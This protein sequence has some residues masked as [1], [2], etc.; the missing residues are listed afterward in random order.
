MTPMFNKTDP[1]NGIVES[2]TGLWTNF[3]ET[4]YELW[5]TIGSYIKRA[6]I[7]VCIFLE[8]RIQVT[9]NHQLC[10]SRSL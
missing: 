4:G 3:A 9:T 8:I 10:G 7:I 2:M 5:R 6:K 1:E